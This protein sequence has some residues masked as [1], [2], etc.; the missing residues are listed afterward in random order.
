MHKRPENPGLS[1]AHINCETV[2]QDLCD[3][4]AIGQTQGLA[5]EP[6]VNGAAQTK[7]VL[8]QAQ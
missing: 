5:P 2:P 6:Y 4:R 8:S 3:G 7:L 1:L